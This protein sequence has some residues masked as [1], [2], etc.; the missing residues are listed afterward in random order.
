M[1]PADLRAEIVSRAIDTSSRDA[2]AIAAAVSAGRTE[3]RP[4]SRGVFAAWCGATG[5]RTTVEDTANSAGH[6]L[7]A[8]ALTLLDFLQGGVTD[9]LDLAYPA[10]LQMLDAWQQAGAITAEQ[11]AQL[12]ALAVVPAPVSEYDVRCAMWSAGGEWLGG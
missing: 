4:V 12:Q 10:N 5:L 9:A 3:D 1:T 2:A 6:P 11:A 8:V 7:R